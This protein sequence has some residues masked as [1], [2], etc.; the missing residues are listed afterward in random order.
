[1]RSRSESEDEFFGDQSD[2]TEEVCSLS[3]LTQENPQQAASH[4]VDGLSQHEKHAI[5]DK[6]RKIGFLEAFDESKE[7]KLQQGFEEGY[8]EA[9]DKSFHAGNI[10]GEVTTMHILKVLGEGPDCHKEALTASAVHVAD[11]LEQMKK[12]ISQSND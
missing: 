7:L 11:A 12:N 1:M 2:N 5:Q 3:I 9:L 10:I 4:I 6:F 8:K